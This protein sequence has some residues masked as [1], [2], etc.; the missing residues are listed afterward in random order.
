VAGGGLAQLNRGVELRDEQ[1]AALADLA[2]K[3]APSSRTPTSSWFLHRRKCTILKNTPAKR[4]YRRPN[5]ATGRRGLFR[6]GSKKHSSQFEDF[7]GPGYGHAS[8]SDGFDG[9]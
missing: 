9:F 8:F 6:L 7:V 4:N 2:G 5:T 1:A 3:R